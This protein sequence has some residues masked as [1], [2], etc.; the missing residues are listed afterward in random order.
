MSHMNYTQHFND[1]P[2]KDNLFFW[3]ILPDLFLPEALSDKKVGREFT[4]NG[5]YQITSPL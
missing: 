4:E 3:A 1:K 5:L 2:K